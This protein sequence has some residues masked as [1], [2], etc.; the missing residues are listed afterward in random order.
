MAQ[1]QVVIDDL[2]LVVMDYEHF[3]VH[4]ADMYE[5][6]YIDLAVANDAS[7]EVLLSCVELTHVT[8]SALTEGLSYAY[9]FEA[10]TYSGGTVLTPH[11]RNRE[12][13]LDGTAPTIA[14][15]YKHSPTVTGTGTSIV[16]GAIV[17]GGSSPARP[18]AGGRASTEWLL[19]GGVD[20]VARLTNKSGSSAW[21]E[22]QMDIYEDTHSY[23]GG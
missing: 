5:I 14:N 15:T 21:M 23:P 9:L 18:S 17:P 10:P 7:I 12:A 11:N 16:D 4:Q 8:F 22:L 2:S 19:A 20:Y 1:A 6:S 3:R 13:A